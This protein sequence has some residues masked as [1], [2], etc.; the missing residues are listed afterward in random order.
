MRFPRFV[1]K[2]ATNLINKSLE[3]NKSINNT[4][5][6]LTIGK[7]ILKNNHSELVFLLG[8]VLRFFLLIF[9]ER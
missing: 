3:Y 4:N 6:S 5:N 9:T 1:N 7:I 2:E 8:C